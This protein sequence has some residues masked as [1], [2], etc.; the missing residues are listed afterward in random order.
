VL[1]GALLRSPSLSLCAR[2]G[3]QGRSPVSPAL[4]PPSPPT[5][6]APTLARPPSLV[7]CSTPQAGGSAAREPASQTAGRDSPALC[8]CACACAGVQIAAD[9]RFGAGATTTKFLA[10]L[11]FT[12]PCLEVVTPGLLTTVQ[13]YPGGWCVR[14]GCARVYASECARGVHLSVRQCALLLCVLHC[15]CFCVRSTSCEVPRACCCV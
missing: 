2:A 7:S 4:P 3:R 1:S 14:R 5:P 13:D 15:V 6:P 9:P 11:V 8:A 10:D 12:S